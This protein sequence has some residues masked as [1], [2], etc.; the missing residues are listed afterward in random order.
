MGKDCDYNDVPLPAPTAEDLFLLQQRL[1]ELENRLTT[2]TAAAATVAAGAINGAGTGTGGGTG[3]TGLGAGM[4]AGIG[5][6]SEAAG[7]PGNVNSRGPLWLPPS[8]DKFPSAIF[9]DIDCFKWAQL[10]IPKPNVHVPPEV[11]EILSRGNAV[12]GATGEY[13]STVHTWFPIISQKRMTIG[14]ALWEGGPDLAMLFLA[15]LLVTTKEMADMQDALANPLY[16]ASKR[17]LALLEG[18]GCLSLMHLQAMILVALYELGHGIY[19]AAW[20]TV[21]QC[22][23]YVEMIGIPS[24]KESSILL[25]SCVSSPPP[26]FLLCFASTLS[27]KWRMLKAYVPLTVNLDRGGRTSPCLVGCLHS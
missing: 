10:P 24:F 23:R 8:L 22:A 27:R 12:H 4:G 7:V 9:L 19:P 15:M 13:F 14:T 16:A 1:A 3:M 17:F 26:C 6:A 20:M 2:T 21:G 11:Y 18:S 5:M 25:G